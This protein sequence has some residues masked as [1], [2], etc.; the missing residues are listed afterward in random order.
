MKATDDRRNRIVSGE[1]AREPNGIDDAGVATAAENHQPPVA[2]ADDQRLIVED[3][4]GRG[5]P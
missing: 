2:E 4:W 1:L 5:S 3:S